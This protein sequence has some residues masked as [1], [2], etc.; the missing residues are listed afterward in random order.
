MTTSSNAATWLENNS[1]YLSAAIAW[2]RLRLEWCVA[3]RS[4]PGI[5]FNLQPDPRT[6]R[7]SSQ[8]KDASPRGGKRSPNTLKEREEE[9][10]LA[11]DK[12]A[13]RM[14][15]SPALIFLVQ[16]LGLSKFESQ[17]L[18][19]C[20]A[21]EFD[22][23]F[24]GLYAHLLGRGATESG[25]EMPTFALAL[26]VLDDP[27]WDA[28]A[29]D[30][31]LRYWRLIEIDQPGFQSLTSSP[32][33]ADERVVGFLKGLNRLDDRLVPFLAPVL[34]RGSEAA[35]I[36]PASQQVTADAIA[37]QWQTT[38]G[39]EGLAQSVPLIQLIGADYASKQ[40]IAA[41]V[42]VTLS[43]RL[44]RLAADA[45]PTPVT[46]IETLSRLWQR[47]SRL[48]PLA[49]FLDAQTIDSSTSEAHGVATRRFLS[50]TPGLIFL[51]T[52]EGWSGI[53]RESCSFEVSSPTRDEQRLAWIDALGSHHEAT[54]GALAAQFNLTLSDMQSIA[55]QS[56]ANGSSEKQRDRLWDLC[57]AKVRPV[58]DKLARRIE[59]RVSW[60][61]I[62]LPE[63][64]EILLHQITAQVRERATVYEKW[65]FSTRMNR[66][67]GIS[68]LFTGESGTGKTMAAEVIAHDLRLNLYRIDLSAVVSKYIGETE[69]NLSQLFDA[70]ENG[71]AI[72][73]FDEADALFGKRSEVK[74]SHD[75]YANIEINYLLQRMESYGGLAILATNLRNALD[76]AFTRRLRFI[77][78][79][80]FPSVADRRRMW[81]RAYPAKTPVHRLDDDRLAR[82]NLTGGSIANVAINSAFL[83]AHADGPV[84]MTCVLAS[85]RQEFIK[86]DRP[87][88]PADF[89][90]HDDE[91]DQSTEPPSEV[92]EDE[93]GLAPLTQE[94]AASTGRKSARKEKVA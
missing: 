88:N 58:L 18:L 74:D 15:S 6:E 19:L 2:L 49:L 21:V 13:G 53:G 79:F 51:C 25:S 17:I 32:L 22:P 80:P 81:K 7:A 56:P 59:T 42:A 92:S 34:P 48:L 27:A 46:E 64:Q 77:V 86:L 94:T 39:R 93:P 8:R 47:E 5:E 62:V 52:R 31:P 24:P 50:R 38:S 43:H 3:Q 68:A 45:L 66:G 29:P 89:V 40:S 67:L 4:E 85:I 30:G 70:A 60:E 20:A 44:F 26:T 83:A 57:L 73:F 72:L 28:L 61:D 55:Y 82:F 36:L 10:R 12:I 78:N 75:R 54:A 14:T 23:S 69:K 35:V 65:G 1:L 63:E 16:A 71:G 90:W 33:R 87:I 9:A 76:L 37:A 11:M 91:G 84:T 41:T